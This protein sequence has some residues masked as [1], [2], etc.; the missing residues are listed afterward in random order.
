MTETPDFENF[1]S[2][3]QYIG[4]FDFYRTE[5]HLN[6]APESAPVAARLDA[7]YQ[8]ND[9]FIDFV[10]TERVFLAPSFR[11]EAGSDTTLTLRT[12]FN[13]DDSFDQHRLPGG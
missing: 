4:N 8:T 2:L 13:N 9:S 12:E 5:A 11:W 6:G 1:A 10:E 3:Q 7:A